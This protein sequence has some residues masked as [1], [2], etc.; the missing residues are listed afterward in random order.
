M[1]ERSD[2]ERSSARRSNEP[3]W[4]AVAL[5]I[6]LAERPRWRARLEE[7]GVTLKRE[8]QYSLFFEDP[9]GNLLAL[10]HFPEASS[11]IKL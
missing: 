6:P 8:T 11:A 3:G 7:S 5:A 1:L 10:S 2:G 4:H 9:E